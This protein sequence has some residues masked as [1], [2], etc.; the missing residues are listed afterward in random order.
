VVES[1]FDKRRR[2]SIAV[3]DCF[4]KRE[5]RLSAVT[6]CFGKQECSRHEE[7]GF[8]RLAMEFKKSHSR[9]QC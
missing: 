6:N 1:Y 5:R 4:D 7:N 8:R 2:R 3:A 9:K